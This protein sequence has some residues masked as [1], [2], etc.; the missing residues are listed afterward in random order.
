VDFHV[1]GAP[2]CPLPIRAPRQAGLRTSFRLA[3]S[4]YR[5][6]L[7]PTDSEDARCDEPMSA[8][9]SKSRAPAPRAFPAPCAPC[10][11]W[12]PHGVFGSAEWDRGTRRFTTPETASAGRRTTRV[13]CIFCVSAFDA[14][15]WAL[16]SHGAV[17]DRAS[18]IP[19][20]APRVSRL[21]RFR[22][23]CV[24]AALPR[25]RRGLARVGRPK[26]RR[27]RSPSLLVKGTRSKRSGIPSIVKGPFTGSGGHYSPGPA[28][29]SPLLATVPPL[30]DSLPSPW[31]LGRSSPYSTGE[32][33]PRRSFHS[34][35]LPT[36]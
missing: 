25:M 35:R 5:P 28:T 17:C 22:G 26:N 23:G 15:A 24:L 10:G 6:T 36:V 34:M 14:A 21:S 12:T 8:I 16:S 3:P 20:A 1:P 13:L 29:T 33:D 2:F 30:D 32:S 27:D 9:Q 7:R 18:G 31:A 19:V 11:A 4:C